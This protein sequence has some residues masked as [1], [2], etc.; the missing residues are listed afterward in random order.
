[1]N[2]NLTELVAILDM[3]GSMHN[4]TEDTIGGYNALLEE[5]KKQ[6]GEANITTVLFDD[7]YIL[8]HDRENIKKVAPLT[9]K[10]YVPRGMTALLDAVGM[11]IVKIGKDLADM[12]EEER[13]GTVMVTIITD[14]YENASREYKW[15]QIQQMIKEQ[16]EKYNWVFSFIGA[17]IDT[18]KVSQDLGIDSRM[19][20]SYTKS[21]AG[22][23]SVYRAMSRGMS[24]S[25]SANAE[26]TACTDSFNEEL[27]KVLD[28]IE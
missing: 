16:R 9:D 4:L 14:G 13:P 1:M 15:N 3:S 5:Q 7:R 25:R 26:G 28:E 12:P 22:A 2:N 17:D 18:A 21:K 23:S 19:A 27:S 6:L 10:Q 11:T 8:L 24:L 20:K